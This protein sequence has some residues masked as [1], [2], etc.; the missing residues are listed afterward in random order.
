M[1]HTT[2]ASWTLIIMAAMIVFVEFVTVRYF[3]RQPSPLFPI[4]LAASI[5]C[6][7]SLISARILN[8]IRM[9]RA[10]FVHRTLGT[11]AVWSGV[12]SAI[13]GIAVTLMLHP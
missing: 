12:I 1:L 8:G 9:K 6:A 4:H 3:G 10:P 13:L 5:L 11:I 7:V 2:W